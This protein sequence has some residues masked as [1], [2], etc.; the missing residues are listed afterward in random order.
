MASTSGQQWPGAAS[1]ASTLCNSEDPLGIIEEGDMFYS[2]GT[3]RAA[4]LA[5]GCCIQVGTDKLQGVA[6]RWVTA[7]QALLAAGSSFADHAVPPGLGVPVAVRP[8]AAQKGCSAPPL[9]TVM[10]M[11]SHMLFLP[12]PGCVCRQCRFW[13]L[14]FWIY[15]WVTSPRVNLTTGPVVKPVA[16]DLC[17]I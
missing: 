7:A 8:H 2:E 3:A 12:R 6:R 4:L 13:A 1:L 11:Q 10:K 17:D 5:A 9:K 16:P 15:A 14:F